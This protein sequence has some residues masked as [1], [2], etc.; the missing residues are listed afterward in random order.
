MSDIGI[1]RVKTS[2]RAMLEIYIANSF[3]S[4]FSVM[5]LG[6][7]T[8]ISDSED[9]TV[10]YMEV[11]SPFKG[12]SDIGS[13]GV[14]GLPMMP[15]DPYAYVEAALQA[16][17]SPDYVPGLEHPPI[18]R[19]LDLADYPTERD[20][21]DDE[22][23]EG[24]SFGDEA[25][26][27]EEDE[28]EDEEHPAPADSVPPSIH[29]VT[30]RMSV[31]AQTPMSLPSKTEGARLFPIPTLPQSTLS[32]WSSP[33]PRILS[34]LPQMLS[35]PLHVSPPPLPASP[36]YPLGYQAAMIRLRSELPS[37]SHPLP[38][39]TPPS[40]TPPLLPIPLPTSSPP[41]LLP[42]TSHR[43][44][45]LEVT[46]PPQK[47]L[48]I[49]LGLRFKVGESLSAP[50]ARPSGDTWDEMLVGISGAPATDETELGRRM[51]YFLTT[52]RRDTNEIY[53]RL[54]DA[55]D[56]KLLM[57]G[58]LNMLRRDRFAHARTSRLMESEARLFREAWVKSMDANDTA[59]AKKMAPKRTIRSTP[60]TTTTTTTIPMT[61]AQL[62]ALI[63][64]GVA[65]A[66]AARDTDR[67]QNG[68]DN[69]DSG[70]GVRRQAP[71][72]LECTY[73]DFM[74]C[75][76][77]YFKGTERVV[78]LT[79][80]FERMET[81]FRISNCTVE[82]QIKFATCTLLGSALTWWNSN[83]KTVGLDVAYAMTWTYLKK[84]MTDKYCPMGRLRSWRV[85]HLARDCRSATNANT[86]NN[87]RGTEAG[88]KPTCFECGAQ[89]YFKRECPNLKNNN[90]GNQA[91]NGN[92]PAKVYAVGHAGINPDSNVVTDH[93]YV[94]EL[95]DGRIIG[96]NTIIRGFT[97]NFLNHSFNIDLMP[98]ELGSFDIIIGMDWMENDQG[99]ETRLNIISC[100]K[101]QKYMIKG[102]HV[103]LAHVTIKEAEDKSEKKR[104][105][106]IPIV[107]DFPDVFPEDLS[108]R[109]PYRLAPF[110]MKEFSDQL[111]E[112]S[113]K[114]FIRP[115]S[116]PWGAPVLFFK[117]KD[118]SLRIS[119]VYSKIDLRSGYHQLQVHEEDIP[120][121][122]FRTRYGHYEFQ[123]MPFGLTNTPA[124]FMDLMNR[125]CKPYL[126]KFVIAFTD[127][128]LI[129]S[130]N[131]EEHEEHLKLI[132]ELLKKEEL[133]AKFSK[134]EFWIPKG[135][136][137]EA[138]FQ[139]IKQKLCS[140]P[141]LAL[142]E[143]SEDF[144]VYCDASHKGLSVVLMQKEKCMVL[145]DHKSL[146]HILDQKEL[147]MRQRCWLELLSDYELGNFLLAVGKFLLPVE[148]FL[149]TVGTHGALY[150]LFTADDLKK[151]LVC[152]NF[153]RITTS[154]EAVITLAVHGDDG[155]IGNP[156]K[157]SHPSV[158]MNIVREM[159]KL[160]HQ[161]IDLLG[162]LKKKVA[163]TYWVNVVPIKVNV[164]SWK[165]RLN[166]LLTR[167]NLSRRGLDLQSI[168]CPSC[169]K[170]V[171]ST[172]YVFFACPMARDIF[173]K[174]VT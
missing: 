96:L 81:V 99:N 73:Q 141:I 169:G 140:A 113:D 170:V 97:L 93:Y 148:K 10:T 78:E 68:K 108:A 70:T 160:K 29:C 64:Q 116:S 50:T 166:A 137:A 103:F 74:K 98:I 95:T 163:K 151:G 172:N 125:V 122:A 83:V 52:V 126:D 110:E 173:H 102:C 132:L 80:W 19:S 2:S 32:L 25:D 149:L 91:G 87:Q 139:L 134:C 174:I 63:D 153:E 109:A 157:S 44:D 7:H 58:Q 161:G 155:N 60:A 39:S 131:K 158:W 111:K 24:E 94:V 171:E 136:K 76:P 101:M 5:S 55:P 28:D 106:D 42:S 124:V 48:C 57:S 82:N 100:T 164:L 88:Q 53:G 129:Y 54:D 127:D 51:T 144:V 56:D 8:V 22:E 65:D 117:K 15:Q 9:F 72:S 121:T 90:R 120:K 162:F 59:R 49:A 89:G 168:L 17:P 128:I 1:L 16:P 135:E 147:N 69:H 71:P 123:V 92:A 27:E 105:E 154:V 46:L 43:V 20:D 14:D 13:P 145:T 45:V 165:V 118:G 77:L 3:M 38:S 115:S 112:L 36:T 11:S 33:L 12:L 167:L 31:Q 47:R 18:P 4:S 75:K 79:Q 66:L 35:P 150:E 26:D 159:A 133:Y 146:Q 107:R 130:K 84:K 143:G 119:S 138:A 114:G 142:P 41:L 86:A 30:A 152:N 40:G 62:K 156:S 104:L 23:E 6:K 21:D 61:N 85:D 37:T 67:S 34:P